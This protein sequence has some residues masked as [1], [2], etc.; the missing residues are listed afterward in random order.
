MSNHNSQGH[1]PLSA[2]GK[3]I[4]NV[5]GYSFW[6]LNIHFVYDNVHL[7]FAFFC[8]P[9]FAQHVSDIG[10][11][12]HHCGCV[13]WNVPQWP[14]LCFASSKDVPD[15]HVPNSLG[16]AWRRWPGACWCL[17]CQSLPA[18]QSRF[19]C[20]VW[21]VVV[22]W[23]TWTELTVLLTRLLILHPISCGLKFV[24]EWESSG[25]V[26]CACMRSGCPSILEWKRQRLTIFAWFFA[27]WFAPATHSQCN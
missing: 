27:T 3:L 14:L 20:R 17:Q 9:S 12:K 19:G 13:L 22:S 25:W 2:S 18:K 1:N 10:L 4:L 6:I 15:K 5:C 16:V 8:T 23:S 7:G 26:S 11:G 21:R 24:C